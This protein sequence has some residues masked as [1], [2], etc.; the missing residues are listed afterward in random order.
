VNPPYLLAQ[1]PMQ[2]RMP[3][4]S[5]SNLPRLKL[6]DPAIRAMI[7]FLRDPPLTVSED[8]SLQEAI[9]RMF[10]MGVRAFLVVRDRSVIGLMT[11]SEAARLVPHH[12]RVADA[13]TPTDHLPA[14][15]WDTLAESSVSDLIEIFDGTGVNY[16]VVLENHSASLSSVR[17][18]IQRKRLHRQLS[19][20]WSLRAAGI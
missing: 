15:G 2:V 5:H 19:S 14:I 4:R 13:M 12:S 7:D 20:P 1:G 8:Y 3:L 18:L 16:L 6:S 9:D 17:G 10:R 11:A